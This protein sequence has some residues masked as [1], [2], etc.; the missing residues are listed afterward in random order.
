MTEVLTQLISGTPQVLYNGGLPFAALSYEDADE[1]RQGLPADVA[2]L[3]RS[4]EGESIRV[5]LVNLS[6]ISTRRVVV[7][8]GRFGERDIVSATS[9][10]E[11]GAGYPGPT[12]AYR[13]LPGEPVRHTVDVDAP[14]LLIELPPNHRA[15]SR[16]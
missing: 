6:M 15:D 11:S 9:C 16:C 8:P 10:G 7:R 4:I 14:E 5:E 1:G 3:V 12:T 2:A 13:S